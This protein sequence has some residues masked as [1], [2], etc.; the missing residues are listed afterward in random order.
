ML[1]ANGRYAPPAG[2]SAYL[3]HLG[4]KYRGWPAEKV[5]AVLPKTLRAA[6]DGLELRLG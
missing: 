2:Q 1:A 3:T 6:Y 4:L 5:N